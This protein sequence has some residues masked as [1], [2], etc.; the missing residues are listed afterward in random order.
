M[1]NNY[2]AKV[3]TE[4]GV[5]VSRVLCLLCLGAMRRDLVNKNTKLTQ[6]PC[7]RCKP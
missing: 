3:Y 6:K 1:G 7:E 4:T 2:Q 5:K